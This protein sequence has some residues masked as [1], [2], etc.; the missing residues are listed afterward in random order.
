MP[1]FLHALLH[2]GLEAGAIAVLLAVGIAFL[3]G[4]VLDEFRLFPCG[5][6]NLFRL[7][8]AFAQH[9]KLLFLIR[10]FG[11]PGLFVLFILLLRGGAPKLQFRIFIF[12][13]DPSGLLGSLHHSIQ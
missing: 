11:L 6:Q 12:P 1:P 7:D 5:F 2:A 8:Q 10:R 9:G 13:L 4:V 3:V